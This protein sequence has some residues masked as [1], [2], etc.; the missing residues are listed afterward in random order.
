[1]D[2]L[3]SE[4]SLPVLYLPSKQ[5]PWWLSECHAALGPCQPGGRALSGPFEQGLKNSH[6]RR[7]ILRFL[8]A[9]GASQNK[10]DSRKCKASLA[11]PTHPRQATDSSYFQSAWKPLG[12]LFTT[13]SC[14][15]HILGAGS[16][17]K[18]LMQN[19]ANK[20]GHLYVTP[21]QT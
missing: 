19:E 7:R 3:L 13:V 6:L 14:S 12:C 1:M 17:Q 21:T 11:D 20:L 16:T 15:R 5:N 2:P 8:P 9:D 18:P 4:L 10:D